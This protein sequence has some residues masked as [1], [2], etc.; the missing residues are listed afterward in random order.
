MSAK[1]AI[2]NANAPNRSWPTVLTGLALAVMLLLAGCVKPAPT[3]VQEAPLHSIAGVV[4]A[5][6]SGKPIA[7][8]LVRVSS[9]GTDMRSVR[10]P[11][12]GLYD[13][14]TDAQGR[15]SI[16]AP[17]SA[18]ISLNAFAPGYEE[19]AGMKM[20]GD[21]TFHQVAFPVGRDEQ[22]TI[23]LRRALYVAGVVTDESGQPVPGTE[24]EA[25]LRDAS[26][27]GYVAFDVTDGNGRFEIFDYPLP[28]WNASRRGQLN[29][30]NSEKLTH[31][32]ANVYALSEAKRT[33]L[34]ITLKSGHQIKGRVT[35]ATGEPLARAV[36][37]AVPADGQSAQ[38]TFVTGA[39]Q[40]GSSQP[41]LRPSWHS[42]PSK[43][44]RH[45]ATRVQSR[46]RAPALTRRR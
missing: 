7:N 27:L 25:T 20:S 40:P 9:P 10:G 21:W 36:V 39:R 18:R 33:N 28:R 24:V 22:F 12:R 29:F 1:P 16:Q 15:F 11:R 37:E 30:Q 19:A 35:T 13:T 17:Q 6:D 45:R 26:S 4:V 8:A 34:H 14:E 23:K 2:K 43:R 41:F 32:I 42:G 5:E 31:V 38:R 3:H 44:S 46:C